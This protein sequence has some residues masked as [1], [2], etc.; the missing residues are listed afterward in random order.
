MRIK[1]IPPRCAALI[2]IS[3][4]AACGQGSPTWTLYRE[5]TVYGPRI[6]VGTFDADDTG[7]GTHR[8]NESNCKAAAR[9][10]YKTAEDEAETKGLLP[11][12]YWCEEGTY[13]GPN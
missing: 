1:D 4:T 6:H 11:T 7:G 10:F 8:Y 2:A 5:G 3:A 12:K 9:L 13:S